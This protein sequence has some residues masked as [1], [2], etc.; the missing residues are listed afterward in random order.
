MTISLSLLTNNPIS[1]LSIWITPFAQEFFDFLLDS[2]TLQ[3]VTNI[4]FID[5]SSFNAFVNSLNVFKPLFEF[6]VAIFYF[7]IGKTIRPQCDVGLYGDE[8]QRNKYCHELYVPKCRLNVRT[9]YNIVFYILIVVYFAGWLS[10]F[11]IFYKNESNV[12]VI[13]FLKEKYMSN[14]E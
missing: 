13:A 7:L 9:V 14:N 11:K 10:F 1:L 2:A 8:K 3:M 12:N 6:L 5:F 4:L